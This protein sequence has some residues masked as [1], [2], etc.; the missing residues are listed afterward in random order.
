MAGCGRYSLAIVTTVLPETMA[1]ARLNE[2]ERDCESCGAT[3]AATLVGS[4]TEMLK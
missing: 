4:A 2:N 1:G 3:T